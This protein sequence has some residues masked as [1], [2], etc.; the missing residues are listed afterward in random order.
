MKIV[1]LDGICENPGDLSWDWLKEYGELTV[2]DR[3][4]KDKIIE[5]SEG[6]EI[7]LTN[8]TPLNAQTLSLLPDL[9][10]IAVIATGYNI[11]DTQYCKEHGITVSNIPSYSTDAV[12]QNVFAH[13]LEHTNH[14]HSYSESVHNGDWSACPDFCYQTFP[15]FELKDK[16]I[17][18]FGY[19]KI[20]K[21]V[22]RIA[23]AFNMKVLVHTSPPGNQDGITFTDL[24]TL[25]RESDF[26]TLHCPLT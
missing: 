7:I 11:I 2:Y 1:I 4:P 20:G 13:I 18:I 6:A 10:F 12:A 8:K 19:G 17:G 9:K 26:I 5:R 15:I 21:Q 24:D 16:T 3:T 23:L 25:I 14:L 22:A